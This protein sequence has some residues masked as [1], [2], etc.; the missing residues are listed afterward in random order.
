M[1]R[2]FLFNR[3]LSFIY[4]GILTTNLK[5]T[6][7]DLENSKCLCLAPHADDE[8]IGMGGTLARYS[9]V[10]DVICLTDGNRGVNA[11]DLSVS[12]KA[13]IRKNELL[14]AMAKIN[15]S[16]V[17]FMDSIP[18]RNLILSNEIFSSFNIESYD[19]IFIPNLLDMHR[20]HKAVAI[21]LKQLLKIKKYKKDLKIVFYEVW[22]SLPM[23]NS[24]VDI[25]KF[26][27]VKKDL[28]STYESQIKEYNY[29]DKS[30]AL[31][32]YRAL[33][34]KKEYVEGFYTVDAKQFKK[35]CRF[36]YA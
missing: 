29:I 22:S 5:Y 28:I 33:P 35:L 36:Y 8:S 16:N 3:I 11:P 15:L 9:S 20:D 31:N 14:S 24:Y 27:D 25:E 32:S 34:V 4:K 18:D 6:E 21:L 10:F 19:Y 2:N 13:E 23:V 12:Q 30:V 1:F 26:V 17:T 7:L